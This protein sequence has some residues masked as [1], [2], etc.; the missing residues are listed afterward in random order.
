MGS[1]ILLSLSNHLERVHYF[2][3]Q[4]IT[5]ED[6]TVEQNYFLTKLRK[7]NLNL[8]GSGIVRGC[9]VKISQIS[10]LKILLTK[11]YLITPQGD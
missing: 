3:R 1:N 9:E 11:G 2:S 5:A 8:H 10:P 4:L 7:H 6:M